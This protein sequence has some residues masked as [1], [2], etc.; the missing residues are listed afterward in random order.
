M[1]VGV[2]LF[3]RFVLLISHNHYRLF[4]YHSGDGNVY[5]ATDLSVIY[6][7]H[8]YH[9]HHNQHLFL[10]SILFSKFISF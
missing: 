3:I 5:I 1:C 10:L 2:S 6:H 8:H 9:H 4:I 7:R